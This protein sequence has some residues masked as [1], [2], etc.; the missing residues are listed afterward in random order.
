MN[1]STAT[2]QQRVKVIGN[3]YPVKDRLRTECGARWDGNAK[4]WMVMPDQLEKANAIVAQAG[5]VKPRHASPEKRCWECG[6]SFSYGD[7]KRNGG[8]WGDSYCG[9]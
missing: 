2:T 1:T 9:C 7:A 4:V 6:C 5:P 8:D 3:T